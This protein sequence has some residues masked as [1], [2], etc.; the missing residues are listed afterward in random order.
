MKNH[1]ILKIVGILFLHVLLSC[2]GSDDN[3]PNTSG[4]DPDNSN[5]G[6]NTV[7]CN[8]FD[9][10]PVPRFD[11]FATFPDWAT[12]KYKLPYTIGAKHL[13]AQG[14]TTGFGHSGFWRFGYDLKMD[15]G[16]EILAARGGIVIH[17]NDGTIDGNPNGTNLITILHDDDTVALYSHLTLN[18]VLVNSGDLVNQGDLI[19]LSGNTGNTGGLPHLHF[20][21]HPCSGLPGLPDETD[22]P[23]MPVTFRNTDANPMGLGTGLCYTAN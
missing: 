20:S 12:S 11:E 6:S 7:I 10:A 17:A 3:V 19:G 15:I 23:T 13:V 4:V 16:T 22:C 18:G 14:N 5:A 21:V 1:T 9:P 8:E 2:S